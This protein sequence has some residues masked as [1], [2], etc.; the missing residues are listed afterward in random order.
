MVLHNR[1]ALLGFVAGA[2][3]PPRPPPPLAP[4]TTPLL[5]PPTPRPRGVCDD[6]AALGA[7]APSRRA[8]QRAERAHRRERQRDADGSLVKSPQEDGKTA[9]P[10][11]QNSADTRRWGRGTLL[12]PSCTMRLRPLGRPTVRESSKTLYYSP[13]PTAYPWITCGCRSW[14]SVFGGFHGGLFY[15]P[16]R[17]QRPPFSL[18]RRPPIAHPRV[19]SLSA[20]PSLRGFVSVSHTPP[21]CHTR[22]FVPICHTPHFSLG[23]SSYGLESAKWSKLPALLKSQMQP[24]FTDPPLVLAIA[25]DQT[26]HVLWRLHHGELPGISLILPGLRSLV[27]PHRHRALTPPPRVS[28]RPHSFIP[29]PWCFLLPETMR[30]DPQLTIAL[31]IGTN[32]VPRGFSAEQIATGVVAILRNFLSRTVANVLVIGKK[33]KMMKKSLSTLLSLSFSHYPSLTT[34]PTLPTRTCHTCHVCFSCLHLT[35]ILYLCFCI[36]LL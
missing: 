36:Y 19:S 27:A 14:V 16:Y 11:A 3:P 23:G 7:H 25:G 33:K 13:L 1:R 24:L 9:A 17:W 32:N 20:I 29:R 6:A 18:T 35:R 31:H 28:P 15:L 2:P 26:Q 5:P 8:A 34:L 10:P 21:I 22:P 4:P 12:E 30:N